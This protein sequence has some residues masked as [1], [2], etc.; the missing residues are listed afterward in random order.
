MNSKSPH[1]FHIPV[2]GI[3]F[4]IDTPVKVACYGINSSISIIEDHLIEKMRAYYYGKNNEEYRPITKQE[5][6]YRAKRIT[7]YLNLV[8][9]E[10]KKK[11]DQVKEAAFEANSEITKYFEM[12]PDT[13]SL[14]KKYQE[15]LNI[16]NPEAQKEI[17]EELRNNVKPGAIEVN[18][19]TKVDKENL[20][21]S[22][23]PIENGSDALQ[24]LKGYAESDLEN[25]TIVFSAGMNPRLF[26]YMG[27]F[28]AFKMDT[29]G[30]F[31]KAV[32]IKVSDY[33][34]A[35]IQGKYL[36]KRGIWVS[37]FRVESGLNCGGHAF[38]TQGFL[39][40]PIL[41]EF[42]KNRTSLEAELTELYLQSFENSD[43]KPLAELPKIKLTV[44]GGIGTHEE[45]LFL[46]EYY[47]VDATGW[48]SPFL[49]CPEATNVDAHTQQQL[50]KAKEKD[51]ILS[52]SSPL[53]VRFNYLKGTSS[54]QERK[55]RIENGKPGSSCPEKLLVSN[56]EFTKKPICTAS[57]K[58][59]RL[60][61]AQ[62]KNS[63]LEP[64]KK[65]KAI[66]E[67]QQKECLCTGLCNSVAKTN[68]FN[69]VKNLDTV[70]IC[71]G[72]NLAYFSKNYSLKALCDHIYGKI[73]LEEGN[74]PHMFIK[75]LQLYVSYFAEMLEDTNFSDRKATRNL[76]RFF[77]NL[78]EGISYYK[79]LFNEERI[80]CQKF[81]Q[82][83]ME[84][85]LQVAELNPKTLV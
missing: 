12:L 27:N 32:A 25:S 69:F 60:K 51:I 41:E 13:A 19:M 35:L 76:N 78:T 74:R 62:I 56:T 63:D 22:G 37:E 67:L 28:D 44:Q 21:K 68:N 42:K 15:F 52:H 18:I 75:E 77:G 83:I 38:A 84:Y 43:E 72:P 36:A 3:S 6:N 54:E 10:I 48:G 81:I 55:A 20:D 79:N 26:N 7:D 1:T 23:T 71:P 16:E 47:N 58:Y 31:P 17:E 29:K 8:N 9:K 73:S 82:D 24:A 59:Q 39:L 11:I 2:M 14:K 4:T 49:L 57:H 33:R 64:E 45:D 46:K 5:E 30:D 40:G 61:L 53:G 80:K 66:D 65:T 85:E 34:S 50:Q 70:T